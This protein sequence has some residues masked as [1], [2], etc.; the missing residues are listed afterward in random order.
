MWNEAFPAGDSRHNKLLA[1]LPDSDWERIEPHLERMDLVLGQTLCES[2]S[3]LNCAYFPTTS[4]LSLVYV[5]TDGNSTEIVAVGNEGFVGLTLCMGGSTTSNRVIVQNRGRVY[6]L[7]GERLLREFLHS[8]IT[9]RVLLQYAQARLTVIGQTAVCYRRH[10]ID[11]QLCRW[12]LLSLDRL[13]SCELMMTHELLANKYSRGRITVVDRVGIEASCCECYGVI[14]RAF[15]R[16]PVGRS[17]SA[18]RDQSTKLRPP[19]ARCAS[20]RAMPR[21]SA[22]WTPRHK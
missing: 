9:Q 18:A 15:E 7:R 14:R 12:L 22:A 4:I 13:S 6:R 8:E 1:A 20:A 11:Q 21:T 10:S 3:R 19:F 16:L 2:D 17:P 5:T